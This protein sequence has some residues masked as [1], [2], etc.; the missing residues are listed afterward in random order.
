MDGGGGV[1]VRGCCC[2]DDGGN[3][4][5]NCEKVDCAEYRDSYCFE[6]SAWKWVIIYVRYAVNNPFIGVS[7]YDA[8][9]V[10]LAD[11]T[12]VWWFVH[13]GT[14]TIQGS[15]DLYGHDDLRVGDQSVPAVDCVDCG[16]FDACP[17]GNPT[18][19]S[20]PVGDCFTT[21]AG[22]TRYTWNPN[23]SNGMTTQ[24]LCDYD[25]CDPLRASVGYAGTSELRFEVLLDYRRGSSTAPIVPVSSHVQSRTVDFPLH[26]YGRCIAF[27][28]AAG[29]EIRMGCY[30]K[31]LGHISCDV[32]QSLRTFDWDDS[33]LPPPSS[34]NE[35]NQQFV[36]QSVAGPGSQYAP[37][38]FSDL[39]WFHAPFAGGAGDPMPIPCA[40]PGGTKQRA[41]V[42]G[43]NGVIPTTPPPTTDA[44]EAAYPNG[45]NAF[46]AADSFAKVYGFNTPSIT[47]NDCQP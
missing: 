21:S 30:P 25:L 3:T 35:P 6:I 20:G 28:G 1:S 27:N 41:W 9:G 38:S 40:C 46:G 44:A 11:S 2:G 47:I 36:T 33:M 15:V 14:F 43:W 18:Y 31:T 32:P 37:G 5:A 34:D 22:G 19:R 23:A 42:G 8:A 24:E 17:D 13:S 12:P 16:I 4:Y 7:H 45:L 29:I 10:P 26:A 39:A